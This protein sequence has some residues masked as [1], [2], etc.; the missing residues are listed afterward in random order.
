MI[1]QDPLSVH[2]S[3]E[4][5]RRMA[6]IIDAVQTGIWEAGL[7]DLLSGVV[8]ARRQHQRGDP[9]EQLQAR[10]AHRAAGRR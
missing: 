4:F 3:R 7:H 5:H 6:V 8:D 9:I 10:E 2:V 1:D